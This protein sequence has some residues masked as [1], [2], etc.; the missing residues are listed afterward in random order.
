MLVPGHA[1]GLSVVVERPEAVHR[2]RHD[3][4]SLPNSQ[5]KPTT[6]TQYEVFS[7]VLAVNLV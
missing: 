3:N 6:E 1:V 4:H 2:N 7:V 5:Y